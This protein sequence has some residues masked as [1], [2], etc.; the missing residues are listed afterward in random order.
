MRRRLRR[1]DFGV[2]RA[3]TCSLRPLSHVQFQV[4]SGVGAGRPGALGLQRRSLAADA[5]TAEAID[6]KD[7]W[8]EMKTDAGRT[9]YGNMQT[10]KT[11]WEKPDG[12]IRRIN[13]EHEN[14]SGRQQQEVPSGVR[15]PG[16]A[17]WMKL[18]CPN[19]G[20]FY[21]GNQITGKTQ[22][23]KPK[24]F[25]SVQT[26]A[27]IK[28]F[29]RKQE[30]GGDLA[31]EEGSELIQSP[32]SVTVRA[33]PPSKDVDLKNEGKR[34]SSV[35]KATGTEGIALSVRCEGPLQSL[36]MTVPKSGSAHVS[37]EADHRILSAALW[38]IPSDFDVNDFQE[39]L[40]DSAMWD[41][42][43][44]D[45]KIIKTRAEAAAK[46]LSFSPTRPKPFM[47]TR[48]AQWRRK[49]EVPLWAS[50]MQIVIQVLSTYSC[51]K[52]PT[53]CL[54]GHIKVSKAITLDEGDTQLGRVV[55]SR[56]QLKSKEWGRKPQVLNEEEKYGSEPDEEA[57]ELRELQRDLENTH[58]QQFEA[59]R[60]DVK[61]VKANWVQEQ[62]QKEDPTGP[63]RTVREVM[64]S[65]RAEFAER[66]VSILR[67]RLDL[68]QAFRNKF[69][70][71]VI[72]DNRKWF[73]E[74]E[75]R[76][77]KLSPED[78]QSPL[79]RGRR[80]RTPQVGDLLCLRQPEVAKNPRGLLQDGDLDLW[81]GRPVVF[82][83][84][85]GDRVR[86]RRTNAD[87][88]EL[89]H[90]VNTVVIK[91][92]DLCNPLCPEVAGGEPKA[93]DDVRLLVPWH[94]LEGEGA[95]TKD[96]PPGATGF[97]SPLPLSVGEGERPIAVVKLD[98]GGES[99][100]VSQGRVRPQPWH[101][102][103][104]ENLEVVEVDGNVSNVRLVN[105][106]GQESGWIGVEKLLFQ[107]GQDCAA[108][109]RA[110]GD[111]EKLFVLTEPVM[112][113]IMLVTVMALAWPRDPVTN[114]VIIGRAGNISKGSKY[115]TEVYET[116]VEEDP[117]KHLV[118]EMTNDCITHGKR[119]VAKRDE[120]NKKGTR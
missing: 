85:P 67:S 30:E 105:S 31:E 86:C 1:W 106:E 59:T 97:V 34:M 26:V 72:N 42:R 11:Q 36:Q 6:G 76:I 73:A 77:S 104:N 43:S 96:I 29:L 70:E 109:T 23:E 100:Y 119:Q 58:Q 75:D 13:G 53:V 74:I 110:G 91:L 8:F 4:R 117:D 79:H 115:N 71:S 98:D 92:D 82:C 56:K 60:A 107:S 33:I 45:E 21:Y 78:L 28:A 54:Y 10:R 81:D 16:A 62:G 39:L 61:D 47:V 66:V 65:I 120:E 84:R 99:V 27:M 50:R 19:T 9:Y 2:P 95:S 87:T 111:P 118:L 89:G 103:K 38:A 46:Q 112:L 32:S 63:S 12:I 40:K 57:K 41:E 80:I 51:A 44:L 7:V 101:W 88:G 22:W 94:S 83:Y 48:F 15:Q 68:A 24:N 90:W 35:R 108:I 64:D 3:P 55:G 116:V 25:A 37:R 17:L 69:K 102:I 5:A 49:V 20:R 113:K 18:L 93:W 114:A 14:N 52:R